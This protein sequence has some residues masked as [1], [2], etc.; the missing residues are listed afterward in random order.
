MRYFSCAEQWYFH[1]TTDN[2]V[3][4][5]PS[6]LRPQQGRIQSAGWGGGGATSWQQPYPRFRCCAAVGGGA[7]DDYNLDSFPST[8]LVGSEV[9]KILLRV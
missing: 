1:N 6:P 7:V 5:C 9:E 2:W 4:F 3:Y 8:L